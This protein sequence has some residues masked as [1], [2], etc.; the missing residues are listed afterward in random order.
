[1]AYVK[2][3]VMI[4][5]EPDLCLFVKGNLE[6]TGEFEV[7]TTSNPEDAEG[8]CRREKPELILLDIVMPKIK[9]TDIIKTLKQ[10][11]ETAH[12][13]IVV[14]SGLG[15]IVYLKKQG[16]WKWLPNRPVVLSRGEIIKEKDP[17]RAAKAYG[18]EG[19]ITKPFTT[20][21]LIEILREVIR[22][23]R[24]KKDHR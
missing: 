19:Y 7:V 13:P 10:S 1:M 17:G 6:E 16:T 22:L 12:I 2:K 24:L 21:N 3:I 8:L 18:V 15:E 14:I 9:G 11:A 20:E 4:D 23:D 5:D